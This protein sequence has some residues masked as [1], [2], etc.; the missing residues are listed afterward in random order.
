MKKYN[1][2][3]VGLGFGAEFIPIYLKHP[4]ANMHAICQRNEEKLNSIGD[5]YGIETRYSDF[6]K[7]LQD[8][9][10][11]VV[12]I[13]SPIHLHAE[14]T[15]KALN[16]GKHVACTVPM[17][18]SVEECKA[19]VEA[20]KRMGK[21]YMMMETVVYAREFLYIKEL[22]EKGE[23][24]KIQFLKASHQQDMDGWPDYWPGLPPMHYATHCVSPC[25]GIVNGEA[26]FVSCLGSG[27]ISES[28]IAKYGSPFS[29]ETAHFKVRS[30]DVAGEVTRYL[31]DA[32]RQYQES[33]DCYGSKT[34]FEWQLTEHDDPVLHLGGETV[35]KVK[36]PDYAHLLP[37]AI[38]PFT[39]KGVY[40]MSENV[41]LSF[42]Q[43]SG[44]GGSHPH[45]VHEFVMSV[46][47]DRPSFPDLHQSVNW[48]LVGIL[49]HE[50]AMR[51]GEKL[52]LPNFHGI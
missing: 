23:L 32:A 28:G 10:V 2:A 24:G 38:R 4:L 50:S 27:R 37:E 51:G 48:T 46:I 9:N 41:H 7:L 49:A 26:E 1:V 45:L 6:E 5:A 20:S 12:H 31:F 35:E 22:Y 47:E 43:G 39:T 42:V 3:I 14:Q 21:K 30:Q 17:A 52:H 33:F 18:T 25:L 40:D 36:I 11:D 44:H 34:S 19:I 16:A 8:P 13:N 15:L 29:F